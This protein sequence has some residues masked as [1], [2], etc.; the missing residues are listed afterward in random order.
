MAFLRVGSG[1]S[2]LDY[3]RMSHDQLFSCSAKPPGT[4]RPI[5]PKP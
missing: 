5:N 4:L 1:Q 3:G 2:I